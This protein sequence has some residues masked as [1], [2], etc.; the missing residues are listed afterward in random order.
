MP[1]YAPIIDGKAAR[2]AKSFSVLNPA[3][4]RW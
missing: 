2:T 4:E 1:D 3:D